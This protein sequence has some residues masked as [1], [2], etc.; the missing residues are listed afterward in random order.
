MPDKQ[1]L[2]AQIKTVTTVLETHDFKLVRN[3]AWVKDVGG[4]HIDVHLEPQN[5]TLVITQ[6]RADKAAKKMSI[7]IDLLQTDSVEW[8]K[9]LCC[10]DA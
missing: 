9:V 5:R 8:E 10:F 2:E 4:C 1:Q 6:H 3:G 7:H